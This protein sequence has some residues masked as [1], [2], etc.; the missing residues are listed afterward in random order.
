LGSV[1]IRVLDLFIAAMV[2]LIFALVYL[3]LHRSTAGLEIR[4]L[5]DNPALAD[6]VGVDVGWTRN[7]V[8][9]VASALAGLAGVITTY[10]TGIVPDTGLRVLF[11]AV[12]AVIAGGVQN[13]MLGTLIGSLALGLLTAFAG[14][15]FPPWVAVAVFLALILLIVSRPKGLFAS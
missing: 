1:A 13:L 7:L 4:A 2:A 14:L 15:L 10:D 8:F 12:V 6:V 11:I 3:W 9:L 5:T